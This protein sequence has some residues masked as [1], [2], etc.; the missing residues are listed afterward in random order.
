M[1]LRKGGS[2]VPLILVL[3][4][5][6]ASNQHNDLDATRSALCSPQDLDSAPQNI[7]PAGYLGPINEDT[8]TSTDRASDGGVSAMPAL[9]LGLCALLWAWVLDVTPRLA[10]FRRGTLERV[11][12]KGRCRCRVCVLRTQAQGQP[13]HSTTSTT[14][15]EN[16]TAIVPKGG[17]RQDATGK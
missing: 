14:W 13:L 4:L 5:S 3:L 8:Q 11:G 6:H 10:R 1:Q 7:S 12:R 15:D 2:F 9:T 17:A 16:R